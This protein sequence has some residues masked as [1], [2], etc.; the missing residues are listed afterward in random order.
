MMLSHAAMEVIRQLKRG[1]V[2][3]GDLVS[4]VGRNELVHHKIAQRC[5]KFDDGPYAGC[6]INELTSDGTKMAVAILD[7]ESHARN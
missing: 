4:K 3:D 2:W 5:R 6:M 7:V 1:P